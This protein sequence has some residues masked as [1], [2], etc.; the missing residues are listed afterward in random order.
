VTGWPGEDRRNP[1]KGLPSWS[2]REPLARWLEEEG[3]GVRGLRVLDV[4]CGVK[5]YYPYFASADAYVGVDVGG[6]PNADLEGSVEALPVEDGA[7]DVVLCLQ[8][9]EHVD[10]PDRA[11][12]ELHRVTRPGGRVLASTHGTQVYHPHPGDHWRW[13][14]TGLER[15]FARNG[16]WRSVR[17]VPGAGT[18]ACLGMLIAEAIDVFTQ[19]LHVVRAGMLINRAV[20]SAAAA[21]DARVR[22]L[23]E[24]VPGSLFANYH[25]LAER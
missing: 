15:L 2:V 12:R 14:H 23:R 9:L 4:G 13:T 19:K 3:R 10:D 1:A 5:P 21:L 6:N 25:V 16:D 7:Y 22:V 18:A 24:P 11:V 20:N 17:V 8:V